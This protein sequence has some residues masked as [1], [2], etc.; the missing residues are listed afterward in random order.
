MIFDNFW[1]LVQ[2]F[3]VAGLIAGTVL[4]PVNLLRI[5][6]KGASQLGVRRL[7]IRFC[8]SDYELLR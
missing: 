5:E 3:A 7:T 6:T 2:R 8:Y 4:R 1:L